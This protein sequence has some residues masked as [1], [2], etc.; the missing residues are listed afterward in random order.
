MPNPEPLCH[1]LLPRAA[2]TGRPV[3]VTGGAGFI[4]SHLVEALLAAGYAVHVV[5]DLSTGKLAHLA[6]VARHPRLR[7]T[8][9]SI[10]EPAVADAACAAAA[11]VF[12]LA[13]AVGV[14]R[15]ASEPLS[16]MQRN[17][18]ASDVLLAAAAGHRCPALL[19]SSSEVYGDG[20]VPFREAENLRPG[21]TEGLRG[22]YACAK[23]MAEWLALGHQQAT[24]TPVLVAR[25]FNTVGP[26]QVAD[27]GM[28]LPRFL[29]QAL[30]GEPITVYG[31]GA[32]T[33]CFA[34]VGDVVRALV[35][36]AQAPQLR[37]AVFNVGSRVETP[38]GEL[39]ELVRSLS[40]SRSP[41]VRVPY[42]EVFPHGFVDPPRRVPCLE[43]L[44]AALGHEPARPL[45]QIV[46]ELV[47]EARARAPGA[48]GM[49]SAVAAGLPAAG[50]PA[51]G[52]PA[53]GLP[54]VAGE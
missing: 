19:A 29:R 39:A 26:R 11:M 35:G 45:L 2:D 4:G 32:Q 44:R 47:A 37:H 27:H 16:V 49:A 40:S 21:S 50:L 53:V 12:H 51:V 15:L 41:I 54:A 5:D 9:A 23:A 42:A 33:R 6:A 13:G 17:L 34:H 7:I 3:L 8:V 14:Q 25:L 1:P 38:V 10:A 31:D 28:V 30:A 48:V 43:R 46:A 36:L 52:L 24:G 22:G 18:R 20:P